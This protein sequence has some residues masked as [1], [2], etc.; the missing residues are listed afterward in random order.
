MFYGIATSGI[1]S[2][3]K[4][5]KYLEDAGRSNFFRAIHGIQLLVYYG[6]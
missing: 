1:L 5:N 4:L 3:D 6:E 2:Q